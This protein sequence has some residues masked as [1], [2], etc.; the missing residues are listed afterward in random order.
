MAVPIQ[1]QIRARSIPMTKSKPKKVQEEEQAPLPE[2]KEQLTAE[3]RAK[4]R[5]DQAA[6]LERLARVKPRPPPEP[7]VKPKE[8]AAVKVKKIPVAAPV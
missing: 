7:I 5:A 8:L 6:S 1:E 3:E 2:P 4:R